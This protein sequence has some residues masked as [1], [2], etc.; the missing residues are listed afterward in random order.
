[1]PQETQFIMMKNLI[2]LRDDGGEQLGW[3]T[4]GKAGIIRPSP[5]LG[6]FYSGP[7][8]LSRIT[9]HRGAKGRGRLEADWLEQ[10]EQGA[11]GT[12]RL[13]RA[14]RVDALLLL[15]P[16]LSSHLSTVRQKPS[17]KRGSTVSITMADHHLNQP[18]FFPFWPLHVCLFLPLF[19]PFPSPI[20]SL[21]AMLYF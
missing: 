13:L 19:P 8:A 18:S 11:G 4:H 7:A 2:C 12:W 21:E 9:C 17:A 3:Q 20:W 5:H 16:L 6:S 1:M 10:T 14:R 15:S